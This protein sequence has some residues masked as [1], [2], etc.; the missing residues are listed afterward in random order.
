MDNKTVAP[1][2]VIGSASLG[3]FYLV[4]LGPVS[5]YVAVG[6]TFYRGDLDLNAQYAWGY[7]MGAGAEFPLAGPFAGAVELDYFAQPTI[8][9]AFPAYMLIVFRV[10]W[11]FG[12]PAE[13]V[14]KI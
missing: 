7:Y 4:D 6:G 2:S 5:P 14:S 9:D 8:T 13:G 11:L 1:V 3:L 10:N 12:T